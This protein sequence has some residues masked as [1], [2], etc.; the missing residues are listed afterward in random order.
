VRTVSDS[1]GSA[2]GARTFQCYD[3][4]PIDTEE[5]WHPHS[6]ERQDLGVN[7]DWQDDPRRRALQRARLVPFD[8]RQLRRERLLLIVLL[9]FE[10][11]AVALGQWALAVALLIPV[12]AKI[13]WWSSDQRRQ[14]FKPRA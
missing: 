8:G 5:C 11:V 12:A 4:T 6:G 3:A 1:V 13:V 14:V 2:G 7:D 10:V 9:G